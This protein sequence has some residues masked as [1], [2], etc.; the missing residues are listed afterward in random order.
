MHIQVNSDHHIV[1]TESFATKI[2]AL[3]VDALSRH[4]HQL[5]RVEVHLSDENSSKEG[6]HDKKCVLEAR[7]AG[8]KPLAV[9]DKA[10][11]IDEAIDGAIA[12]L[13]HLLEHTFGRLHSNKG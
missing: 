8:L 7:P 1:V 3:V 10:A 13:D 11:T 9:S 6:G 5:T 4:S 12:K 2:Q